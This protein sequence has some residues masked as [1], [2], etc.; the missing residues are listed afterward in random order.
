MRFFSNI[1]THPVPSFPTC[2]LR[3]SLALRPLTTRKDWTE[4]TQIKVYIARLVTSFDPYT[5]LP[6]TYSLG[7]YQDLRNYAV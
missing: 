5:K 1:N 3:A 7:N 2:Q 6:P 4:N